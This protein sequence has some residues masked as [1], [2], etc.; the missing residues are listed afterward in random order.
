MTVTI[1]VFVVAALLITLFLATRTKPRLPVPP[2]QPEAQP[3]VLEDVVTKVYPEKISEEATASLVAE[4]TPSPVTEPADEAL[5]R[6]LAKTST[7]LMSRINALLSRP[8]VDPA[9]LEELEEALLGA[10]VGVKLS[11]RLL[12]EIRMQA[13]TN[14]SP[15]AMQRV[16]K[17]RLTQTLL[18][19]Q[20]NGFHG[21]SSLLQNPD[22][23][24]K[25]VL[26]VGV[27]GVGKTTTIGKIA[28]ELQKQGQHVVL[29]AGDTFRAAAKEQ[30]SIWSE[31]SGAKI[32]YGEPGADPASVIFN[33][34]AHAKEVGAHIVLADTAGRLHTKVEL[35]D[36]IKKV[37]RAASKAKEGA[38][39]EVWLV[40]DATTG[41]N[42]LLQAK[43]F[44]EALGL[45]GIILTKLDG[46]AKGGVV[47]AIAD[48]LQIPVRFIGVGEKPE[49]L[50]PFHAQG[51]VSALFE[52]S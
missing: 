19:S 2:Q 47:I 10:D 27:N 24:P 50:R 43:E 29:A 46:T 34:V 33:A 49:D 31:R 9:V 42:A 21:L 28:S 11:T 36:E 22:D 1:I 5:K 25:V 14:D 3:A 13:Q 38:P 45:T 44:H 8:K 15:Q 40:V 41:Q 4:K 7:S 12:D 37:K 30:L 48:A 18:S 35:M 32:I 51:F 26:F 16:L 17:E 52:A 39:H 6:G 23:K 20:H